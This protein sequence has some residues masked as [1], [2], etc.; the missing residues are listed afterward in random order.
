MPVS[1]LLLALMFV[2]RIWPP[3]TKLR[4][5]ER[6]S[7]GRRVEVSTWVIEFVDKSSASKLVLLLLMF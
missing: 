1:P 2:M 3:V 4:S 7:A 6:R 5:T